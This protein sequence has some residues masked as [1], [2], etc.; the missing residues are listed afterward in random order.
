MLI[1]RAGIFCWCIVPLKK[2]G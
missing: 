2:T 1:Q